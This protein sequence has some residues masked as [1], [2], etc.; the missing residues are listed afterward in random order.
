[1][2]RST[3]FRQGRLAFVKPFVSTNLFRPIISKFQFRSQPFR[4]FSSNRKKTF[5]DIDKD[6]LFKEIN[7]PIE[8]ISKVIQT[9]AGLNSFLKKVINTTVFRVGITYFGAFFFHMNHLIYILLYFLQLYILAV[10]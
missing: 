9:D 8:T 3:L 2:I 10:L 4:Q 7:P 1:M 5:I 6:G